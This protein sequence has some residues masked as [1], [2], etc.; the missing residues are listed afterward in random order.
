MK[1][2]TI[3]LDFLKFS[4]PNKMEFERT[5]LSQM[6]V[7]PLF[8]NPD[9]AYAAVPLPAGYRNLRTV[10]GITNPN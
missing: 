5:V 9:V 6:S 3:V 4:V 2:K 1:K 8:A 10:V 7:L